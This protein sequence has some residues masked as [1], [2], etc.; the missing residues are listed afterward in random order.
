MTASQKIVSRVSAAGY[1]PVGAG[2]EQFSLSTRSGLS[3]MAGYSGATRSKQR[4][5]FNQ[6]KNIVA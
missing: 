4:Y 2:G 5:D 1:D 3:R 6:F